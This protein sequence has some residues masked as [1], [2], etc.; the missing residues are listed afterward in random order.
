MIDDHFYGLVRNAAGRFVRGTRLRGR[1]VEGAV[2]LGFTL[3]PNYLGEQCSGQNRSYVLVGGPY[4]IT[5]R[6]TSPSHPNL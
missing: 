2:G 3:M 1:I 5:M 6:G 4:S